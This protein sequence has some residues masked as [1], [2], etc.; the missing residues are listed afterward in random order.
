MWH[1]ILV[2]FSSS[3]KVWSSVV[4]E[5]TLGQ[6]AVLTKKIHMQSCDGV[7]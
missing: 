7:S 3:K 4:F 5:T 1:G 2:N 6:I